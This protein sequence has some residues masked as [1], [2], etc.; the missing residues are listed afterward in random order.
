M[1]KYVQCDL[2]PVLE[3]PNPNY[4]IKQNDYSGPDKEK[5]YETNTKTGKH[6]F[7]GNP[8]AQTKKYLETKFNSQKN[9]GI[10]YGFFNY[11][12]FII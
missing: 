11:R 5:E 9:K 1:S 12:N 6:K 10:I 3:F 2:R 7:V 4:N 8:M